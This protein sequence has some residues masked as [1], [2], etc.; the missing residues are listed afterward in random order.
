MHSFFRNTDGSAKLILLIVMLAFGIAFVNA[1][2]YQQFINRINIKVVEIETGSNVEIRPVL[3]K[4]GG[5]S[6]GDMIGRLKP[7][8]AVNGTYYDEN[9]RPLGDILAD[10]KMINRG[11]YRNGVG[12]TRSGRVEFIRKS[13]GRL[14]WRGYRSGVAAG[15]RLVTDGKVSLDPVADGFSKRSLTIK[16]WRTGIARKKNGNMLLVVARKSLTLREFADLMVDLGAVQALNLDGGGACGL[17]HD[18][19]TLATPSLPMTNII[20][21]YKRNK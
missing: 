14:S 7:Y 21:V 9:M 5:E 6:F 18:G 1:G 15:P 20:A 16:A 19:K 12:V 3:A 13:K 11:G 17:Y 8:A 10:G 4:E 2:G